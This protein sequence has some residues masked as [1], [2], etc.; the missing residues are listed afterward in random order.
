[1]S[2][3]SEMALW[4]NDVTLTKLGL[5][6]LCLLVLFVGLYNHISIRVR[7]GVPMISRLVIKDVGLFTKKRYLIAKGLVGIPDLMFVSLFHVTIIE[8][9]SRNF[10][11]SEDNIAQRRSNKERVQVVLYGGMAKAIYPYKSIDLRLQYKNM[12]LLVDYH[13]NEFDQYLAELPNL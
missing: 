13:Q 2:N 11:T 10:Y 1:M 9:K 4:F 7:Y 12:Q 5:S 3:L 8:V 6:V